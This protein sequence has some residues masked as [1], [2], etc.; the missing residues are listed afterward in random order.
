M[1]GD[2]TL[3]AFFESWALFAD[4]VL[5]G[6][7]AGAL[8]GFLGVY[9]VLRRMVFLSAALSQTAS[10]GVTLYFLAA[11]IA[12]PLAKLLVSPTVSAS[13]LALAAVLLL[14]ADRSATAARRDALLGVLFLIGAAGTLI[15]GSR[16][17]QEMHDVQT[18]LFGSAV[19]VS[20]ED[21]RTLA[22]VAAIVFAVHAWWWRGFA[23]ALFDPDGAK[24][25]RVPT[26]ALEV[27]LLV[28]LAIAI[29]VS[30]RV[31]GALPTFAF[32]L[33][34]ALAALRLSANVHRAMFLALAFGAI[35]GFAG[36]LVAFLYELPVGASQAACG[37][38]FPVIAELIRRS[39]KTAK[40]K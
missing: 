26:G 36:Y 13:L 37:L 15:V 6:T 10:F 14:T 9:I 27:A 40:T 5:A 31:L 7:V 29:S 38:A 30:T 4:S 33:F 22:I 2:L 32:S 23:V 1:S 11:G 25:R 19:A 24:V 21:F 16:I 20:P 17:V 8:L 18:L 3:R 39:A 12:A 28:T 35:S 34:P